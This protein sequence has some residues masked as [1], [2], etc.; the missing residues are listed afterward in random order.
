MNQIKWKYPAKSCGARVIF[1]FKVPLGMRLQ[2]SRQQG[3]SG[4]TLNS[5]FFSGVFSGL[6][7]QVP[8][9]ITRRP[10]PFSFDKGLFL[11]INC[12]IISYWI[13]DHSQNFSKFRRSFLKVQR[14]AIIWFLIINCGPL[15]RVL[16]LFQ[17]NFSVGPVFMK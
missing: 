5:I 13:M 12:Y 3:S 8:S 4:W 16:L 6:S 11:K 10:D 17:R 14:Y 7:H 15:I 9:Y 2:E 1:F